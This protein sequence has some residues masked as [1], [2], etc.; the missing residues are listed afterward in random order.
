MDDLSI[1]SFNCRGLSSLFKKRNE[2][3]LW[4]RKQ[5][6]NIILLQ[7]THSTLSCEKLWRKEWGSKIS[8]CHGSRNSKGVCILFNN[9]FD[10]EI[11]EENA[12]MNGR[13]ISVKIKTDTG[14]YNIVNVYGPNENDVEFMHLCFKEIENLSNNDQNI[15]GATLIVFSITN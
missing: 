7:E 11:L 8:F 6:F 9:N 14:K 5:N 10:Y 13:F 2:L 4:L 1:C 3:F 12:K 15:V